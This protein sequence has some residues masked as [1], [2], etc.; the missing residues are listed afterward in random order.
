MVS[1]QKGKFSLF[2]YFLE[3]ALIFYSSLNKTK[4]LMAFG[5]FKV[6]DIQ[7][8]AK[9]VE[10]LNGFFEKSCLY[11]FA[12]Q[13]RFQNREKIQ[14]LIVS[15]SNE[16][17]SQ[18]L[19]DYEKLLENFGKANVMLSVMENEALKDY[20]FSIFNLALNEL[21]SSAKLGR[22]RLGIF[23]KHDTTLIKLS[24]YN[25]ILT[26]TDNYLNLCQFLTDRELYGDLIFSVSN[27]SKGE[28][29]ESLFFAE[30]KK[31]D[32]KNLDLVKEINNFFK[33]ERI[34]SEFL[35]KNLKVFATNFLWRL[36]I[37]YEN[38]NTFSSIVNIERKKPQLKEQ[39]ISKLEQELSKQKIE[40]QP[41]KENFYLINKKYLF[42]IVAR[43]TLKELGVIIKENISLYSIY[44]L[45][46][47]DKEY[48][49]LKNYTHIT[50][51]KN[52][53][54]LNLEAFNNLNYDSLR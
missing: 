10:F 3:K 54:I 6:H 15:F 32:K 51:I 1:K 24:I 9:I 34:V 30:I 41:L 8:F 38:S 52:L 29:I 45:F 12:I 26:S 47:E 42:V 53:K 11:S 18:I 33:S 2:S 21:F 16:S 48:A 31:D 43:V 39:I 50:E 49:K 37:V 7:D 36:P 40:F 23:I 28:R 5:I 17:K 25:F 27:T 13:K 44:L 46:P 35:P 14:L 22:N 19:Q 20:F 4:K